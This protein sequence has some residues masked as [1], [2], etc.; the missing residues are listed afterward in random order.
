MEENKRRLCIY[1]PFLKFVV[2]RERSRE[3]WTIVLLFVHLV[4]YA[5]EENAF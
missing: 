3:Q 5:N 2:P 1:R 4:K